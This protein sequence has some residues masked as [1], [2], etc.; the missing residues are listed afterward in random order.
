MEVKDADGVSAKVVRTIQPEV[1]LIDLSARSVAANREYIY[2]NQFQKL[3]IPEWR[4]LV[5]GVTP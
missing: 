5:G 3:T 2:L 1:D 4:S